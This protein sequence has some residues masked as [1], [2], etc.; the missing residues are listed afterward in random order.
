MYGKGFVVMFIVVCLIKDL[1]LNVEVLNG[2]K[3]YFN[4]IW[5]FGFELEW[6]LEDLGEFESDLRFLV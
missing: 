2:R 3:C 4:C 1:I 6:K 5:N